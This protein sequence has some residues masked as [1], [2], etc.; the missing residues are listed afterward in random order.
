M[1]EVASLLGLIT[2]QLLWDIKAFLDSMPLAG[3]VGEAKQQ[4]HQLRSLGWAERQ[5]PEG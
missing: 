1:Q 3:V 5:W 4:G 2:V